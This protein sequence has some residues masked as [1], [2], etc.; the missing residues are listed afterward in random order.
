MIKILCTDISQISEAEYAALF[1]KASAQRQRRAKQYLRQDDKTRCVVA[2]ALVRYAV[3][4]ALGI[5]DYTVSL[6]EG[7]KPYIQEQPNFHFNLSHSGRWVV[8]AYGDSP[9]GIDI[10]Q[11]HK[12]QDK[13]SKICR[14][15]APDETEFILEAEG[16]QQVQRFFRVW[17]SKES[18]LKYLGIGLRKALNSFSVLTDEMEQVVRFYTT[19]RDDYCM[20]L[21]A[22]APASDTAW[23]NAKELVY[24]LQ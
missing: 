20:T 17:T 23:I 12:N 21:C 11:V 9:V 19:F 22:K 10:Q 13:F 1:E 8:I 5:S 16:T 6:E 24:K 2:D 14:L 7:G 15:F 4:T 18:Y 3:K